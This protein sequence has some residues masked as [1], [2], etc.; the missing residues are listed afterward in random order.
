M[1]LCEHDN[2]RMRRKRPA[3]HEEISR[4]EALIRL[5]AFI[6]ELETTWERNNLEWVFDLLTLVCLFVRSATEKN[7]DPNQMEILRDELSDFINKSGFSKG[8]GFVVQYTDV[9]CKGSGNR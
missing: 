4:D 8:F 6:A 7:P 3:T 2:N 5:V 1:L 9:V